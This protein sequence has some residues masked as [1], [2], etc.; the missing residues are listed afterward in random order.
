MLLV[1]FNGNF[2]P[3]YCNFD[4]TVRYT[5]RIHITTLLGDTIQTCIYICS[6]QYF[7]NNNNY[8]IM[9]NY[10]HVVVT[11]GYFFFRI[12]KLCVAWLKMGTPRQ[13]DIHFRLF[14]E[15]EW[16]I[17]LINLWREAQRER[18][19]EWAADE[20]FIILWPTHT[21]E[22]YC[23]NLWHSLHISLWPVS[24]VPNS[25]YCHYCVQV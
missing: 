23:Q 25:F 13:S 10:Y 15:T 16:N 6:T 3:M 5:L 12:P 17:K 22:L 14:L 19:S 9:N 11:A 18:R 20:N 2:V 21:L 24:L 7:K 8:R 1:F 4:T